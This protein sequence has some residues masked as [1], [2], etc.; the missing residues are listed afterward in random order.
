MSTK[1]KGGLFELIKSLSKSEK[2]YF[3][4]ISSRHTIG[5]ENNY[6]RLF[7]FIDKQ[8]VYNEKQLFIEFNGEAF[9]HRF[10]ITKKRLYDH[11]LNALDAYYSS[12]S[13]DS[14]LFKLI[15]SADI[16]YKKS[17]YD[18][19][20]RILRSA[21]KL[22]EKHEKYSILTEIR[23]K[24][25][26]L[27]ENSAYSGS[28]ITE[29]HEIEVKDKNILSKIELYNTLW[30]LKS[31]MFL[32]LSRKGKAR[33]EDEL[34]EYRNII[35]Q[36]P[37]DL[38]TEVLSFDSAYLYNHIQSAFY[39]AIDDME[40]TYIFLR[41]N[42]KTFEDKEDAIN[43]NL[44]T[45]FSLLTNTIYVSEQLGYH[46]D[47]TALLKVLKSIPIRFDLS[48]NED[49]QIKLFASSI[50]IELSLLTHRG[51]YHQAHS[52]FPII[53]SGLKEFGNKV[54]PVRKAF[55][56]FKLA[57]VQLGLGNFSGALKWINLILNDTD[58]DG[59]EDILSYTQI[60]ELLVH[61]EMEHNQLLPYSLKNA[62]RFLK[63]RNRLY[64]FERVF[65]QFVSK[66]IKCT[67]QIDA[68]ILWEELYN[69]LSQ[70]Q[71][72]SFEGLA[73]EYFDFIA[74]AESKFKKTSFTEILKQ[75]F[76]SKYK[77]SL[78]I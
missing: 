13:I 23:R 70:I 18:Q 44:N 25:K 29:L 7:D 58:L 38:K 5:D 35:E 66:R 76:N 32:T 2:R 27:I 50:S 15:H 33:S 21:E 36:L 60:L 54:S 68:Q 56:Q 9:L 75:K 40:K 78:Q 16:L 12:S 24:Q 47:S 53:E 69:E 30:T 43:S 64:S 10:S 52:L 14:Q 37:K 61:L 3:K 39:F 22:A 4:L 48:G 11:V 42:L 73:L 20:N 77:K 59:N 45:Y 51:E 28:S 71:E 72:D 46:Q 6:V 65:L 63:S 1:V 17:L 49:L 34:F 31:K 19:C 67:N 26:K 55:I 8:D 41:A 57:T 74:W 62:Q